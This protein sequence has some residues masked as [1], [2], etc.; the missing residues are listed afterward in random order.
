M[1]SQADPWSQ[2]TRCPLQAT[3]T[4]WTM[5]M[6]LHGPGGLGEGSHTLRPMRTTPRPPEQGEGQSAERERRE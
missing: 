6:N 2:K 1:L 4:F 5:V 3:W